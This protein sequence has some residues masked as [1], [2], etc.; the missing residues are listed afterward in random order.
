M[1]A[2]SKAQD[3]RQHTRRGS[4]RYQKYDQCG[5]CGRTITAKT[6]WCHLADEPRAHPFVIAAGKDRK[7]MVCGHCAEPFLRAM[8]EQ[9]TT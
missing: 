3:D 5:H 8:N 4:G 9:K 6:G 2:P 7:A 1:K